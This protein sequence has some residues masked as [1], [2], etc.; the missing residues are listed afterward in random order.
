MLMECAAESDDE[1][2][3]KYLDGEPLTDEELTRGLIASIKSGAAVPVLCGSAGRNI[4]LQPLLDAILAY[5]PS[6]ADR[7]PV[8]GTNPETMKPV[9]RKPSEAEPLSALVF[10]TISDPYVGKLTYFRVFSGVLKSDSH[11]FNTTRDH[12]ERIGQLYIL[13]GKSQEAATELG[14]GDSGAGARLQVTGTGGTLSDRPS[15]IVT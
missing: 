6:P 9:E 3:T 13:R 15:P 2:I 10:K 4:G 8:E 5:V 7:P 11:V 1:L 12:D 14:A